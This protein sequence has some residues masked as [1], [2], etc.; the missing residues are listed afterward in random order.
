MIVHP[1]W[2]DETMKVIVRGG[3][4]ALMGKAISPD[5]F[6]ATYI[7]I[8]AFSREIT[9]PLFHEIGTMVAE[10]CVDEFFNA[11]VQRLIERGLHVGF[12]T[13]GGLPWA[14]IDDAADL[15]FA[16]NSV[17]PWLPATPIDRFGVTDRSEASDGMPVAC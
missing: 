13:T 4:V 8:T 12:T 2:R 3:G 14:E 7:G 9:A 10:G 1:E 16:Q 5:E 17:Y 6:S 11:A 15:R